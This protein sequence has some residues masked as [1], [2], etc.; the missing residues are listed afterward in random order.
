[1]NKNHQYCISVKWTGN[2]GTGTSNYR[3]L[4]EVIP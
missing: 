4:T 1:M 3:F 2:K